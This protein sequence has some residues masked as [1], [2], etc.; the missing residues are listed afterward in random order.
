[1]ITDYIGG[2]GSAE[3]PKYDYVIYGWPLSV[4]CPKFEPERGGQVAI[5]TFARP[6]WIWIFVS[7]GFPYFCSM[8]WKSTFQNA[9]K[10]K[11]WRSREEN[12]AFNFLSF[13]LSALTSELLKVL[14]MI[15]CV[16]GLYNHT[17]HSLTKMKIASG[18]LLESIGHNHLWWSKVAKCQL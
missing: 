10:A 13:L 4:H 9:S 7:G 11:R 8:R 3:T 12:L 2:E 17:H 1:M 5:W 6:I 16:L 15:H 14:L 18:P